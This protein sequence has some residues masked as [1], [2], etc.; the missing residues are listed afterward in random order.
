MPAN[1]H[2][3][4]KKKKKKRG[5]V[6]L[7]IPL[8]I[9]VPLAFVY[10]TPD[11]SLSLELKWSLERVSFFNGDISQKLIRAKAEMKSHAS[12][13]ASS[14]HLPSDALLNCLVML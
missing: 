10:N 3:F 13:A 11:Y 4:V 1:R 12:S 5:T 9:W 7:F 2:R 14:V 6:T 8:L